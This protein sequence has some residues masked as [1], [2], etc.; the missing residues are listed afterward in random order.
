MGKLLKFIDESLEECLAAIAMMLMAII[1]GMQVIARYAF[2]SSLSWPE[3]ISV[4]LLMWMGLISLSYC[5]R[6]NA[7]IKVEMIINLFPESIQKFFHIM[8][9][10]ISIAFYTF[11]CCPGWQYFINVQKSGQVSPAL[12][13]PMG[14]V[15]IAPFV[16]FVL[17]VIRSVQHLYF[18]VKPISKD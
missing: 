9:D 16:S 14:F 4:Y 2:N 6:K 18:T 17:M 13:L 15:A 1:M 8:E 5:V 10:V 3:E 12:H 7:S 11:L